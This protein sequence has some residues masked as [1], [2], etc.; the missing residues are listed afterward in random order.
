MPVKRLSSHLVG[1]GA[2]LL[3]LFSGSV[4]LPIQLQ[5]ADCVGTLTY[6]LVRERR[7]VCLENLRLVYGDALTPAQRRRLAHRSL[8]RLCR[9]FIEA[10]WINR[11]LGSPRARA[12]R[13]RL[14]GDWDALHRDVETGRGG[15]VVAAHV[16]NW[17]VGARGLKSAGG[18]PLRV[19][20][21][22]LDNPAINSIATS[23]RGGS[24][25]LIRKRGGMR[26]MLRAVREGKWVAMA[27]DQ[28]A[29]YHG[30]FVPFLGVPAST[31]PTAA[32]LAQRLQVP[33]YTGVCLA[34]PG[35]RY[36]FEI[37]VE[38]VPPVPAEGDIRPTLLHIH[39]RLE[40]HIRAQPEQ[41]VW[42]HRRWKTRPPQAQPGPSEPEYGR[43]L[44]SRE[45]SRAHRS[46]R[47]LA[48]PAR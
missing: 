41:Y 46:A 27:V 2:N 19:V 48:E 1:L 30:E 8:Q 22:Q 24:P 3:R 18:L 23:A 16:G 44:R 35:M 39:E 10:A 14:T 47:R 6:L 17:E 40:R 21:R 36:G 28:N 29:G 7:D 38:R 45:L 12:R 5:F 13:L 31:F 33:I 4:P 15:L 42:C 9:V 37:H 20:A 26:D 34:Q 32:V 43:A 25:V 11:M